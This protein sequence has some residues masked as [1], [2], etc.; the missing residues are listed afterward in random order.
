MPMQTVYV[1]NALRP[2]PGACANGTFARI[3][4]KKQPIAA[5]IHVAIATPVA[6]IPVEPSMP[7]LTKIM[8]DIAKKVV[9]PPIISAF[10]V[11]LCSLSLNITIF[12]SYYPHKADLITTI[13]YNNIN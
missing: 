10:T 8:Y 9:K 3:A 12:L 6:F 7:G 2:I 5:E 11:V 4:V 13:L 1:K